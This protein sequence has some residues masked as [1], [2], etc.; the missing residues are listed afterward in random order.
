[1]FGRPGQQ[2][3]NLL[4]QHKQQQNRSVVGTKEVGN[5]FW[6]LLIDLWPTRR[7]DN[8]AAAARY[9]SRR[10]ARR[11]EKSPPEI[12]N[13][14]ATGHSSSRLT[15][16]RQHASSAIPPPRRRAPHGRPLRPVGRRRRISEGR[17]AM[18]IAPDSHC[19]PRP[20]RRRRGRGRPARAP[21][22]SRHSRPRPR[23]TCRRR[24]GPAIEG[25]GPSFKSTGACALPSA[26]EGRTHPQLHLEPDPPQYWEAGD[27]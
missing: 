8:L 2:L 20:R 5:C 3:H 16:T 17:A 24:C 23:R 4:E 12:N 9:D 6:S 18:A 27:K 1:M 26:D 19:R 22:R 7:S 11:A 14:R 10:G 13:G 15:P 21:R 25:E